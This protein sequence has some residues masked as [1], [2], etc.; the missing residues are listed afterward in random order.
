MY[1]RYRGRIKTEK[2][3]ERTSSGLDDFKMEERR[4]E[5]IKMKDFRT[6][7]KCQKHHFAKINDFIEAAARAAR[8]DDELQNEDEGHGREDEHSNLYFH[9]ERWKIENNI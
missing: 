9:L 8:I 1:R 4:M 2:E 3:K 7:C 6:N 5:S